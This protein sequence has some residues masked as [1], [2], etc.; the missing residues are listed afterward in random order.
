LA[1]A[2]ALAPAARADEPV[3]VEILE[4]PIKDMTWDLAKTAVT[5]RYTEPAFGFVV[6]PAK[7]ADRGVVLDRSSPF[8]VRAMQTVAL[9]AGDYRLLLRSRNAARLFLDDKPLLDNPFVKAFDDGHSHVPDVPVLE[10]DVR[11]LAPGQMERRAAVKLDGG[12]HTFRLEFVVGGQKLR[13]EAGEPAVAVAATGQPFRLLSAA[14]SVLFSDG[15][16]EAYAAE[17]AAR[18]Q[19]HA[20][21]ARKAARAGED[22]YWQRRHEL[23]RQ[24]AQEHPAVAV[25][26]LPPGLPAHNAIDHFIAQRLATEGVAPAPLTDDEAFLR[27]VSL[28]TVGVIPSPAEIAAFRRDRS[29]DRR[30]RAVDRLLADP[31][32]ADHWVSYWQDVLAENPGLVKPKLNNTGPFRWWIHRALVDNLPMDQFVTELVRMEGSVLAGEPAGFALASENDVP[33]AAKAQTLAKAF[34]A[35]DLTCARCHDAPS[36]AFSQEQLFSLAAMLDGKPLTVP[37]TSTVPKGEGGRQPA[38]RV[39]LNVG[40]KVAPAW[41]LDGLAPSDVPAEIV[42]NPADRRERVAAILTGPANERFARVLVNRVWKRLLG[43]GLVEPVDNWHGVTPS[44]AELLTWLGRELITHDY[45]LKHVTRLILG[46]HAYQ[47]AV[48]PPAKTRAGKVD[49]VLFASP[50]RRRL[51]AEQLLDSLF[52]AA[53]KPFDCEELTIDPECRQSA[54]NALNLGVPHRAWQLAPLANERDRPALSFPV[55]QGFVDLLGAYG[56]RDARTASQTERDHTPTPLQPMTLANGLLHT[57]V[58]RLSDDSALT[59]LCLEDVDLS[60]LIDRVYERVLT[61]RPSREERGLIAE[62]LIEGYSNRR[63]DAAPLPKR[64]LRSAVSWSNHLSPEAT[65]MKL[66]QEQEVRAGDPPTPRLRADWRARMEDVLWSLFS[67]PEF[68]FVP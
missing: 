43:V 36:R 12:R 8:V 65:R 35:A 6:V 5:E 61:R 46:S 56:W 9:P 68:V 26:E 37:A 48:R 58:A 27:R 49:P 24:A 66:E 40:T 52:A 62:Q 7:Y 54:K 14:P 17:A 29:P 13:P 3:A 39:T 22:R 10:P 44:H 1:L 18:H 30:A 38:V 20:A 19:A 34:L 55:A 31:R 32:W 11:P 4:G 33:M 2:L 42:H 59:A 53:G 57:R 50:A 25:P 16:W 28:D 60:H 51:T 23:A 15:G 45:D 41:H 47:R 64:K 21:A 63:T 67:T